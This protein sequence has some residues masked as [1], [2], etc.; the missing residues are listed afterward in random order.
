MFMDPRN[1]KCRMWDSLA[2]T[3]PGRARES[4]KRLAAG[5]TVAA[6]YR[7]ARACGTL[8]AMGFLAVSP[9]NS[10]RGAELNFDGWVD[11]FSEQWVRGDPE[12][13]TT[14][15]YF[16]GAEQDDLDRQ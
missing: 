6:V 16:D 14:T 1:G 7:F 10:G 13:A 9:A 5:R 12:L 3:R 11:A 15:Q 2:G 8:L 4:D